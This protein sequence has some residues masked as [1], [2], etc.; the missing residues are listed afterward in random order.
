M[1]PTDLLYLA[2]AVVL[3][4]LAYRYVTGRGGI[5][6]RRADYAGLPDAGQ[7]PVGEQDVR[8][9]RLEGDAFVAGWTIAGEQPV[10]LRVVFDEAVEDEPDLGRLELTIG[11]RA[12]TSEAR[13]TEKI[14]DRGLR[15]DVEAVLR[16]LAREARVAR[17]DSTR[18]AKAR[19]VG[20]EREAASGSA[21]E[22]SGPGRDQ[23]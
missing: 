7:V 4:L 1:I 17:S 22:A 11:G 16:M 8:W 18:A 6:I 21:D 14:R 9:K 12:V 3:G 5:V 19:P 15:A 2:L 20:D 13:W 23:V 10:L